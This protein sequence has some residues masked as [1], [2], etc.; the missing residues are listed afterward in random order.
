[1]T[2]TLYG[3]LASPFVRRI[4]MQL[5][6]TEYQ[7]QPVNILTDEDRA[8]FATITPIRKMPVLED[9]GSRIFDS[10][11][12]HHY[13][14]KRLQQPELTLAQANQVS[15]IDA[16]T[17]SMV[18]LLMSKRSELPVAE[19]RLIFKL[20]RERIED[21]LGWLDQQAATG[22]FDAWNYAAIC[23]VCL[24]D[25]IL[26]RELHALTDYP[27]LVAAA[28]QFDQRDICASTRP[29]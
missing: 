12:I 18:I 24:V 5:E 6:G 22:Q 28:R 27:N 29:L 26:F 11:V 10:H 2:M 17:D 21:S 3:S 1:M 15:V 13:L 20:Q 23:I 16:V 7:L 9:N 25:W 14:Q 4:R 8:S 19:D